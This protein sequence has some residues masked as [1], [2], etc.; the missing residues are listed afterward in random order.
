MPFNRPLDYE[1]D[2]LFK[3]HKLR[4]GTKD[5]S[6]TSNTSR[7]IHRLAEIILL[8]ALTFGTVFGAG[9][10]YE[11]VAERHTTI[12]SSNMDTCP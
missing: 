1:L 5:E 9:L 2:P 11:H 7:P 4:S 8:S 3:A 6:D 12:C 10:I